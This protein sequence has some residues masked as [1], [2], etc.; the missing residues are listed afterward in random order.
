M[1]F[2]LTKYSIGILHVV[3]HCIGLELEAIQLSLKCI[4]DDETIPKI[5]PTPKLSALGI[6]TGYREQLKLQKNKHPEDRTVQNQAQ[7]TGTM[8]HK[9][10]ECEQPRVDAQ[11]SQL[12]RRGFKLG[13]NNLSDTGGRTIVFH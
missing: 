8:C 11:F 6:L 7:Y 3:T 10:L 5:N 4:I 1:S 12:H 13:E 9:D 2:N